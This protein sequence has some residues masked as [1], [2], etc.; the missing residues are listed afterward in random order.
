MPHR[1]AHVV[2]D[3]A[4]PEL[5]AAFWA[6]ALGVAIDHRFEQYV[7]LAATADG[8]PALAFQRVPEPK[9][10]KNRLHLDLVVDD[11]ATAVAELVALGARHVASVD[12]Q[13]VRLEVLADPEGNE[14]CV[15]PAG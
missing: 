10:G 8:G 15:I 3:C 5:L 6:A 4:D 2:V 9:L 1:L 7:F 14:L 12:E 13:G 11:L